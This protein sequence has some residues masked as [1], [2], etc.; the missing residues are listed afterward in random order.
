MKRIMQ[1]FLV[2]ALLPLASPSY[3][4][5]ERYVAGTHYQE[6]AA[7]VNTVDS[8][9]VEVLEAFWY[10]CSHCFRFE[11]VVNAWKDAQ[12]DDV[13]FVRFPAAW[14]DLMKTH[15]KIYYVLEVLGAVDTIHQEVFNAINLQG[16]I[17]QR[18]NL[19]ADFFEDHG[20]P[21]ERYE[22]AASS[23]QVTS[24]MSRLD[25]RM[26]DYG[27]RSTPNMIVNGKYLITTGGQV[28]TQEEMLEVVE[29]LVEKERQALRSSG[30]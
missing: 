6:L 24:A 12:P 2:A 21:K 28:R 16:N 17:L 7:P 22:A 13:A 29:F 11:P 9:K 14:N 18:E 15:A 10:G 27:I 19:I 26:Q 4:Q 30:D 3:G 1:L 8:S 23:F 20:V 5:I 25:V